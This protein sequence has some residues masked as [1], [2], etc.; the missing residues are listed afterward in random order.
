MYP[1]A[2]IF[3]GKHLADFEVFY[4]PQNSNSKVTDYMQH[5]Y[6]LGLYYPDV[7][8]QYYNS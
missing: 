2:K 3:W 8:L 4:L 5:L 7:F 6:T 1:I